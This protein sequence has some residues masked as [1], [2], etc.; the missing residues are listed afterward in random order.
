MKK[1]FTLFFSLILSVSVF[2]QKAGL[3]LNL[4]KDQVY[5]QVT[6]SKGTIV[7][8]FN[9]QKLNMV[10]I[11]A[12]TMS[13]R[14]KSVSPAGYNMEVSF[15]NLSMAM[16]V[17][18][19]NVEFN[20]EKNDPNDI[21]STVLNAM[22]N[23]PFRVV[24]SKSGKVTEID[25]VDAMWGSTIDQFSQLSDAQKAQIKAQIMKSYG[26]EAMKGSIETATAIYPEK[27]VNK[28]DKWTVSTKLEAG[29]SANLNTEFQYAENTADH[30]LLRGTSTIATA[31]KDAYIET[32]GIPMKYD[33]TGSQVSEIKVDKKTGWI[34]EAKINQNMKGDAH[35]KDNPQLPGGMTIPMTIESETTISGK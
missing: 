4:Q 5:K 1:L 19:G 30:A 3:S 24:M 23:K 6:T 14:V 13:Y 22:K 25:G 11:M 7:Q 21:F 33:I 9:G 28:G 31:D 16:Q 15:D 27:P 34:L 20:S 12:G 18:Q 17:P 2:A 29:M 35:I 8:D 32:N 26:E 10:M